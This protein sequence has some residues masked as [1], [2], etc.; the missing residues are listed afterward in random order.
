MYGIIQIKKRNGI[1]ILG[2]INMKLFRSNFG[3]NVHKTIKN[4]YKKNI[5]KAKSNKN[6]LKGVKRSPR[7]YNA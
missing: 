7:A 1:N 5:K 6:K 2:G 3:H 4:I